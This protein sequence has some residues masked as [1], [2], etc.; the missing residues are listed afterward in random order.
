M[1]MSAR[2][3]QEIFAEATYALDK[4]VSALHYLRYNWGVDTPRDRMQANLDARIVLLRLETEIINET[5]NL[6]GL[7]K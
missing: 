5:E 7:T 3:D 6:I 2:T 4:L 1:T